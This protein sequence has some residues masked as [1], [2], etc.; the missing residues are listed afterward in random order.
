MISSAGRQQLAMISV[1]WQEYTTPTDPANAL[2]CGTVFSNLVQTP[3]SMS[4]AATMPKTQTTQPMQH[5]THTNVMTNSMPMPHT[6]MQ[7][8]R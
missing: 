1:P 7:K 6:N 4:F 2:M 5:M 8:K 3:F